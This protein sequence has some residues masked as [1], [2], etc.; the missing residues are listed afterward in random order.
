[1]RGSSRPAIDAQMKFDLLMEVYD[2]GQGLS[3]KARAD[4]IGKF[5]AVSHPGI[6]K[7]I[8]WSFLSKGPDTS[9][10]VG[11]VRW[12]LDELRDGRPFMREKPS[13]IP[14]PP[15]IL[16]SQ[17]EKFDDGIQWDRTSGRIVRVGSV[18][19][20][21]LFLTRIFELLTEVAPWLRV[22]QRQECRRFF[23]YQRPK[24][25]YCSEACAQRVRMERFL[26]SRVK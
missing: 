7:R 13:R 9:H 23:L 25:V 26:A 6:E 24:Q 17:V 8:S 1:M 14:G 22:C 5:L 2:K 21:H 4:L 3:T 19:L 15:L 16:S 20:R 12:G 18:G 10:M 11:I